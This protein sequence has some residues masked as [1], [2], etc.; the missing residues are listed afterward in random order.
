MTIQ[1]TNAEIDLSQTDLQICS[2]ETT[3]NIELVFVDKKMYGE[4]VKLLLNHEQAKYLHQRL[5]DYLNDDE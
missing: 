4:K 2:Y 1:V 5:S 3:E